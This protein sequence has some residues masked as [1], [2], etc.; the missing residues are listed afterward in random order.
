LLG[1]LVAALAG[2]GFERLLGIVRDRDQDTQDP[3]HARLSLPESSRFRFAFVQDDLVGR[4]DRDN[5][6]FRALGAQRGGLPGE[7]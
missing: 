2:F 1:F 3:P 7:N 6:I 5:D 4:G